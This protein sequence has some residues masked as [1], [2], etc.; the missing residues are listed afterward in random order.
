MTGQG[1]EFYAFYIWDEADSQQSPEYRL[2]YYASSLSGDTMDV[3]SPDNFFRTTNYWPNNDTFGGYVETA[4]YICTN[5]SNADG[6]DTQI[7]NYYYSSKTAC[8]VVTQSPTQ[9]PTMEPS[10]PTESPTQA[11]TMEPSQPTESPTKAPTTEPTEAPTV[12]PSQ[13]TKSPTKAPTMEP[14]EAPTME[15]TDDL[16]NQSFCATN[17]ITVIALSINIGLVFGLIG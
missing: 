7:C 15:R 17:K 6:P 10:Q 3:T 12:E 16:I 1:I 2:T 9:S 8:V 13:P 14:T 5:S 11:P 4:L